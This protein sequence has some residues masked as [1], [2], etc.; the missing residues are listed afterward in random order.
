LYIP[1]VKVFL[2]N[3]IITGPLLLR[4]VSFLC[5]FI[6][7]FAS[8][9]L[10][11]FNESS[12]RFSTVT[13][14]MLTVSGMLHLNDV[15]SI[16]KET[17]EQE[18][19][20]GQ[21][22][23]FIFVLVL[24]LLFGIVLDTVVTTLI[25]EF[26]QHGLTIASKGRAA[27]RK[28]HKTNMQ[29]LLHKLSHMATVKYLSTH[30]KQS[31]LRRCKS[32]SNLLQY[33]S[34]IIL[35]SSKAQSRDDSWL[36]IR[37]NLGSSL[38]AHSKAQKQ[39]QAQAPRKEVSFFFDSAR[40]ELALTTSSNE[41]Q[42]ADLKSINNFVHPELQPRLMAMFNSFS[43]KKKFAREGRRSRI[44]SANI[45]PDTPPS[46]ATGLRRQRTSQLSANGG[47]DTIYQHLLAHNQDKAVKF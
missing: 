45:P 21:S 46:T 27:N 40:A 1:E 8:L 42:K 39:Q 23:L 26:Y 16:L 44:P 14:A 28:A 3:L 34:Q 2:D 6:Y 35:D 37:R 12:H 9:G 13:D 19:L 24:V 30:V 41:L 7:I 31:Q 38:L 17:Q 43:A 4:L 36:G 20:M 15:H 10:A 29:R 47:H 22:S 25:C 18:T 33:Q 5:F 32:D 11:L